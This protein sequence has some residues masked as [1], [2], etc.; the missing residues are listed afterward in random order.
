MAPDNVFR[1]SMVFQGLTG[2]EAEAAFKPLT[3]YVAEHSADFETQRALKASAV[4]ASWLWSS[5]LFRLVARDAVDFDERQGASWSDFWW[6]G[7]GGQA[8]AFWDGYQSIWLPAALL[9]PAERA[10]LADALFAASRRW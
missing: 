1:V 6:K 5:W 3:E 2:K 8:G 4:W 10:A 9:D 7:D